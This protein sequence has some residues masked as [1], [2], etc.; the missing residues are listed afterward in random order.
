MVIKLLKFFNNLKK[1]KE[2]FNFKEIFKIRKDVLLNNSYKDFKNVKSYKKF[3][4]DYVINNL[5]KR[6]KK[7]KIKKNFL[8][9]YNFLFI[10]IDKNIHIN[11]DYDGNKKLNYLFIQNKSIWNKDIFFFFNMYDNLIIYKQDIIYLKKKKQ[12][13]YNLN[14]IKKNKR[15]P[16]NFNLLF[17]NYKLLK[18]KSYKTKMLYFILIILKSGIEEINLWYKTYVYSLLLL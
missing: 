14:L 13:I 16:F 2:Y 3:G 17:E 9:I 10:Y 4:L 11:D 15:I 5:F 8:K 7:L 1:N 6:G 18:T 12:Y